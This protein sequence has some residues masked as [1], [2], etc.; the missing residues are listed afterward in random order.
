MRAKYKDALN[1][2]PCLKALIG[3]YVHKPEILD[4]P[5]AQA[6]GAGG[7]IQIADAIFTQKKIGSPM[8]GM[9]EGALNDSNSSNGRQPCVG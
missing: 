7:E 3:W 5:R 1:E 8:R 2:A 4:F 9:N 6:P